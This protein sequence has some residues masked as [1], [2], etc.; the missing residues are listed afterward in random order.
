MRSKRPWIE[1][2]SRPGTYLGSKYRVMF[3]W[4]CSKTFST[5]IS[6]GPR[7]HTSGFLVSRLQ[8]FFSKARFRG[9]TT[10]GYKGGLT[11]TT[12]W[13]ELHFRWG[14]SPVASFRLTTISDRMNAMVPEEI[15]CAFCKPWVP[16]HIFFDNCMCGGEGCTGSNLSQKA[17][18]MIW[19]GVHTKEWSRNLFTSFQ[20]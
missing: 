17:C 9:F 20:Q 7:Q 13:N 5:S 19:R 18:A 14:E 8:V 16:L 15:H 12:R 3:T 1:M 10:N 11:I 4:A 2:S 6:H